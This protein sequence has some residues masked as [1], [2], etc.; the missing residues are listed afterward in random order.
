MDLQIISSILLTLNLDREY[1]LGESKQF[2]QT[3]LEL[4]KQSEG[5]RNTTYL[6]S[7]G[8]PT[9]GYGHSLVH[10]ECYSHGITESQASDSLDWDV[11]EA[12]S[13]VQRLVKVP[14]SQGHSM[15]W[16][17]LPPILAHARWPARPCFAP[18]TR[19]A[20]MP[21]MTSCSCGTMREKKSAPASSFAARPNSACGTSQRN[22]R[23]RRHENPCT[24]GLSAALRS[25]PAVL[26]PSDTPCAETSLPSP[27]PAAP[28]ELWFQ[29][30][31][32]RRLPA[33]C[34]QTQDRS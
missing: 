30:P 26:R 13:A 4:L 29:P 9:I 3:G 12:E 10:P 1:H 22:P 16:L 8:Y 14:L 19:A 21:P 18:R 6:E 27:G 7:A 15:H 2:S 24:S 28:V 23:A 25:P 31:E 11:R 17:T 32:A 5:F 33:G 20:T 34:R